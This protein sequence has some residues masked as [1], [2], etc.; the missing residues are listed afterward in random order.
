MVE[1]NAKSTAA[2]NCIDKSIT[3]KQASDGRSNTAEKELE[4][5]VQSLCKHFYAADTFS[6]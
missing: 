2:E 6:K 1:L 5:A 4:P 3:M